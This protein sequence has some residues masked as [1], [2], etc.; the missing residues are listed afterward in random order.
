MTRKPVLTVDAYLATLDHPLKAVVVELRTVLLAV[1]PAIGE[2]V[3]WNAPSF[4]TGEHF[5]TMQLRNPKL[6]QLILHLGA[7][8]Q[9][10]P[11]SAIPDP[12]GLLK[13]L[14]EDRAVVGFEGLADLRAKAPALQEI[15]RH[16]IA[17]VGVA[18]G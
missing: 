12:A 13:W 17:H 7:R 11:K 15:V 9:V 8:K 6:V 14:G 3:K 16:W 2:E 5:A 4:F 18:P 1:D 10:L